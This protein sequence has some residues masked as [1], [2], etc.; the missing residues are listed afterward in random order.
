MNE[1]G[2]EIEHVLNS[3]GSGIR[4]RGQ[5]QGKG[6]NFRDKILVKSVELKC[7][8]DAKKLSGMVGGDLMI[9][10]RDDSDDCFQDC[11]VGSKD[12]F[13]IVKMAVRAAEAEARTA[14]ASLE[15]IKAAGDAAAELV[16]TAALEVCSNNIIILF[17]LIS[18]H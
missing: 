1:G 3:L 11:K 10:E 18:F 8:A 7:V 12:I 15:A 6:R 9:V 16:K 5:G 17:H 4:L 13:E 14:N 2:V